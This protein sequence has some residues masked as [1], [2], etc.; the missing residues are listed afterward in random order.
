MYSTLK[1]IFLCSM[2]IGLNTL[3][4]SNSGT[5]SNL[6]NKSFKKYGVILQNSTWVVPPA[7]LLAFEYNAGVETSVNDQTVWVIN[8]FN[9]GYFFGDTYVAINGQPTSHLKLVGSV[10]P[11][12]N[13]YIT[14]FP[15]SGNL[16]K[17]DIITGIGQITRIE[18]KNVFVM[19]MNSA[20]NSLS[21][22][23]H[24]SYMVSV[25]QN[26]PFYQN[27]PSVNM[28]VPQFIRL[29]Q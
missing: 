16:L 15:T 6:N 13:V 21:G 27:L 5:L 9:Q 22:L 2:L 12:G 19:Q 8:A 24:W 7:S 23:S 29:F 3:C 26:S 25:G 17:T 18:G 20:Q 11:S 1:F 10:T 4:F 14:F 28:S